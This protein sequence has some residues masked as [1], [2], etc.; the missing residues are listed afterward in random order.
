MQTLPY[1]GG[2]PHNVVGK[3]S[4]QPLTFGVIGMF[5]GDNKYQALQQV[6]ERS[7]N[8]KLPTIY[9][10]REHMHSDRCLMGPPAKTHIPNIHYGMVPIAG[11]F[12]TEHGHIEIYNEHKHHDDYQRHGRH[13]HHEK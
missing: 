12:M 4:T 13:E 5:Q 1:M 10:G 7:S 3:S 8:Y 11:R 6:V 9:T 2:Y